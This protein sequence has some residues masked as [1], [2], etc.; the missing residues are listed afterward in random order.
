MV[1]RSGSHREGSGDRRPHVASS[2]ELDPGRWAYW[3]R[4]VGNCGL[5]GDSDPS[6]AGMDRRM[7]M[8]RTGWIEVSTRFV[9][10]VRELTLDGSF[11]SIQEPSMSKPVS[12]L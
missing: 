12:G 4:V 2:A 3:D 9:P 7:D 5:V 8:Y 6:P 1:I 10:P 11:I